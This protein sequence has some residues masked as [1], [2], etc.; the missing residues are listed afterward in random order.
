ML[1]IYS[2]Y[3]RLGNSSFYADK[4]FSMCRSPFLC[5]GNSFFMLVCMF[6]ICILNFVVLLQVGG[7][8][9]PFGGAVI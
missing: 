3:W 1:I 2:V 7:F 5:G 6:D 8:V 4:S 9:A